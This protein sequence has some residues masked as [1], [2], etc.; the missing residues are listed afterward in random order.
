MD[1]CNGAEPVAS[2]KDPVL[3]IWEAINLLGD[4]HAC[5]GAAPEISEILTEAERVLFSIALEL[6]RRS[7]NNGATNTVPVGTVLHPPSPD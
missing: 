4:A 7:G 3:A 1:H 2:S 6:V 5:P